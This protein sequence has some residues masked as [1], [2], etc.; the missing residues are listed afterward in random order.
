VIEDRSMVVQPDEIVKTAWVPVDQCVIGCRDR[1]D[2]AAIE[3]AGR[4][5]LQIG[6]AQTWP[7]IN[8]EWERVPGGVPRCG[9]SCG[10]ADCERAAKAAPVERFVVHDGRHE[11]LAALALGR[12]KVFVAWREKRT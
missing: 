1:M 3:R 2:F 7:P 11:F 6:R 8:G 5:L 9:G 4:K 10:D 12:E